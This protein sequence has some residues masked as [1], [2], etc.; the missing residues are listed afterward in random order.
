M[1]CLTWNIDNSEVDLIERM[2]K[3]IKVIVD[4]DFDLICLQEVTKKMYDYL[5]VNI[6]NYKIS[7]YDIEKSFCLVFLIKKELNFKI[8]EF[9]LTSNMSR[10]AILIIIE[11]VLGIVNVHLESMPINKLIRQK[12]IE[13]ILV[14]TMSLNK[15]VICG[16]MNFIYEDETIKNFIDF[17]PE[18][19]SYNF[20]KN[21]KIL[22]PWI[23]RLDRIFGRN[24]EINSQKLICDEFVS[25]H[26]GISFNIL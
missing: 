24:V 2:N 3:I 4:Y 16:D 8:Y 1:K 5:L 10:N 13:E 14:N 12:Q 17:S 9:K 20:K 19:P 26:F 6:E 7:R 23:S 11:N 25:D 18:E 15:L 21:K 22:G